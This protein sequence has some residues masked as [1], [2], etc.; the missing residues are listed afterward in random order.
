MSTK[1]AKKEPK[2]S[3]PGTK[4]LGNGSNEMLML[5]P[6]MKDAATG[7]FVAV[8]E[9]DQAMGGREGLIKHLE[10]APHNAKLE[11]LL[12]VLADPQRTMLSLNEA[13]K[14]AGITAREFMSIFREASVAKAF[15]D[16][17]LA[18]SD[19]LRDVAV[20]VADKATNHTEPCYCTLGGRR[21]P[22]PKCQKCWGEGLVYFR[23]SLPH[24]QM[25]FET[26]GLL[27]RGGGVN[28]NV[29]QQVAVGG[30]GI[31]ERFVKATDEAAYGKKVIDV[32]PERVEET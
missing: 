12:N 27:K 25:V 31:F 5:V 30:G 32:E 2:S 23:G 3:I 29:Q 17:N 24:Q 21:D 1:R 7:K 26:S 10:Y 9:L 28:V 6:R 11:I 18:L 4:T 16:A 22:N 15:T 14:D 8:N 20:D 13:V 19:R